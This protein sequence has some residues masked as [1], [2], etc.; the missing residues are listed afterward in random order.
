VS[1]R[2][3]RVSRGLSQRQ[4]AAKAGISERTISSIET[5]RSPGRPPTR[6]KLLTALGVPY[7]ARASIFGLDPRDSLGL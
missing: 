2:A 5:G 4:L 7:A 6:R 3:L 1:L